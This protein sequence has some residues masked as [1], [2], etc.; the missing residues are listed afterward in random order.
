LT[1]PVVPFGPYSSAARACR[2][3][4][5][6]SALAL[7]LLAHPAA[8]KWSIPECPDIQ[9]SEFRYVKLVTKSVD[10]TL[11][12][13][14]KAAFE[15]KPGG[16]V[17]IWFIERHGKVKRYDAAAKTVSVV[18]ALDVYS[19]SPARAAQVGDTETGLNGIAL[20]PAFATNGW[21]YLHYSA[22]AK[23]EFR[24][25][26]FTVAGGKLETASE[27]ILFAI[28]EGRMFNGQA[29]V[30]PG[31]SLAFDAYGDLWITIGANCKLA[32]SVNE[33]DRTA[34]G[35]ASSANLADL[36]GSILRVHP[37]NS[38]KGYTVPAGN[39]GSYWAEKFAAQ[40]QADLAKEYADPLKVLPEIWVKGTRNPYSLTVD[41]VRRWA[42]WGDF[43]PNGYPGKRIEEMN[44]A[45]HPLYAGYPYWSGR[46]T[47]LLT[48]S[49]AQWANVD[50]AAPMNASKWNQGPRQ[51]PPAEPAQYAYAAASSGFLTGNHPVTGPIYRYDGALAS[52]VKFPPHFEK[53]WFTIDQQSP[54]LRVF[55]TTADG[56]A[57]SDSLVFLED[58]KFERPL[59][60][61]QGPDGALYVVDYGNVWHGT[62]NN[63]AIGRIEYTG[64]CRPATPIQPLSRHDSGNGPGLRRV[65]GLLKVDAE[66]MDWS[67]A[68]R[69]LTGRKIRTLTGRGAAS[70]LITELLPGP[71]AWQFILTAGGRSRALLLPS[72]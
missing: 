23:A 67:L 57:I 51:L 64:T 37:D 9:R 4:R 16:L 27:K 6:L 60:L 31:G 58:M 48:G 68:I 32:P 36:R 40:G 65:A 21:I 7:G 18:G 42:A 52:T 69:D 41:P 10:P 17:D 43:G 72:L 22:W 47:F 3:A 25:S 8:A 71:G 28:P 14:L 30:L 50:P 33:T 12:E 15:K 24:V 19:D 5:I 34:S 66:G 61:E 44:L 54:G 63:V 11:D 38:A 49:G 62:S 35:E 55:Q 20:D 13:P 2:G 29:I 45:S 53:S 26:R 70:L 59:D 39:F 1:G 56:N 46:N